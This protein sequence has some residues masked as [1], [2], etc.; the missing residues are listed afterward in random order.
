[1]RQP[2][3]LWHYTCGDHGMPGIEATGKLRPRIHPFFPELG[4][5]VWLTDLDSITR[6]GADAVGLHPTVRLLK[7]DRTEFRYA[8]D[9]ARCPGLEHWF[10]ARKRCCNIAL[11]AELESD[12]WPARWW[13]ATGPVPVLDVA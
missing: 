5:V 1:M 7:C 4:P 6:Y 9:P 12:G 2:N 11:V 13:V 8:V 10:I 3:I